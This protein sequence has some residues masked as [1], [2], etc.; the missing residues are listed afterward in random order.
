M[1]LR[2]SPQA[3][4]FRLSVEEAVTL[5]TA[6]MLREQVKFPGGRQLSFS[7]ECS[8]LVTAPTVDYQGH[9]I[10][11]M[12]P[13]SMALNFLSSNEESL[14]LAVE[15]AETVSVSIEKDLPCEPCADDGLNPL[16]EATSRFK[17]GQFSV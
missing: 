7:I 12:L 11:V 14:K 2:L 15:A 4:R 9:A 3:L 8:D 17:R 13:T 16:P 10:V 5:K 1:K 6:F